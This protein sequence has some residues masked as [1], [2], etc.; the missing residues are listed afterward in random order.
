[1]QQSRNW[2]HA[3][4]QKQVKLSLLLMRGPSWRQVLFLPSQ[5]CFAN[6]QPASVRSTTMSKTTTETMMKIRRQQH[7]APLL[8][9]MRMLLLLLR[10]ETPVSLARRRLSLIKNPYIVRLTGVEESDN[11]VSCLRSGPRREIQ[12]QAKLPSDDGLTKGAR[13]S[14]RLALSLSLSLSLPLSRSLYIFL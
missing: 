10:Q 9:A 7:D 4:S 14:P 13:S 2:K 6:E 12:E 3:A 11:V 1:M 8:A 5:H